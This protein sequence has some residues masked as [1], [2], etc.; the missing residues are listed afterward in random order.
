MTPQQKRRV[1]ET[2][3]RGMAEYWEGANTWRGVLTAQ[4]KN[5]FRG[6]CRAALTALLTIADVKM[7]DTPDE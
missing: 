6:K 4:E 2:M 5:E 1:V 7:K 3:A